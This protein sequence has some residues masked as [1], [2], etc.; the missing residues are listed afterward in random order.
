MNYRSFHPL[1]RVWHSVCEL[2]LEHQVL[3]LFSVLLGDLRRRRAVGSWDRQG[4]REPNLEYSRETHG[5][6]QVHA[7][8]LERMGAAR[9]RRV[10]NHL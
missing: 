8:L 2:V 7:K 3:S 6:A 10:P 9:G 4:C 5:K 1:H